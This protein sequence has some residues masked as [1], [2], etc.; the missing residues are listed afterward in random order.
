MKEY[1]VYIVE[2]SDSSYYSGSTDNIEKRLSEHNQG[3][4]KRCYTYHRR[5]VTLVYNEYFDN[6]WEAIERERQ[7]KGWSRA[8]KK[9]LIESDWSNLQK[10]SRSRKRTTHPSTGSG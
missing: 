5:P 10:L 1:Y 8:K 3:L 4:Y 6:P 9:A 7:I 2:C